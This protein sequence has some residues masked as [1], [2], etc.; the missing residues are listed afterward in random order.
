MKLINRIILR[1]SLAITL[2]LSLW[3]IFFYYI[4]VKE[5][6]DEVDDSLED[7]SEL[8][9]IRSLAGQLDSVQTDG[10]NNSYSLRQVTETYARS[11]PQFVYKDSSVY[12]AEKKETEPARVLTTVFKGKDGTF[13]ELEVSTPTFE[14]EDLQQAIWFW[15]VLLYV[16]LLVI[17][18]VICVWVVYHSMRPLYS[19]LHWLDHSSVGGP[20]EPLHSDTTV[21]EFRTLHAAVRNYA[22]RSEEL[23]EQQKQFIGNASH[24][25]QTPIAICQNRLE[26]LLEEPSCTE[27]QME[28][29]GKTLHTLRHLAKLNKSLLLLS[30]I[31][32]HQFQD[33]KEVNFNQLLDQL[34]QDYSEVYAYK[35]I[36]FTRQDV[37]LFLLRMDESLATIL[38]T[39]LLK[40][41]YIHTPQGGAIQVR[42]SPEY[43]VFR[44][45][46]VS[47]P[48]DG[49]RIFT[50]FYQKKKK[51]GSTGLGLAITDSICRIYGIR[52]IYNYRDHLHEFE[53]HK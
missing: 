32:N 45:T 27:A 53:I 39:N 28:E 31:D 25:L 50:R 48:L 29:I 12:I 24:E 52:L 34:L 5:I 4:M 7:Y 44:N 19:L 21:R 22:R 20:H 8:I 2:I 36:S 13:F 47:G 37:G 40:N 17:I 1:L 35:N 51:E 30:K 6:N 23:F 15:V 41:A 43:L 33:E 3:A 10:T 38:L 42:I 14:R 16:C 46:A 9:I 11:V 26:M 49:A 18:V